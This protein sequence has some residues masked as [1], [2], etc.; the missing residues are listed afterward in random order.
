MRVVDRLNFSIGRSVG[1]S[2]L[3]PRTERSVGPLGL[4]YVDVIQEVICIIRT[5]SKQ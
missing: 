4:T 2:V 1:R 5:E 3:G